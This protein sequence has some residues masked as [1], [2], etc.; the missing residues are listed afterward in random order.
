[1]VVPARG[2]VRGMRVS[3]ALVRLELDGR[4]SVG[5]GAKAEVRVVKD[6]ANE[7]GA[8]RRRLRSVRGQRGVNG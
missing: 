8:V 5:D 7:V 4:G 2:E 6:V 3:I 1:M